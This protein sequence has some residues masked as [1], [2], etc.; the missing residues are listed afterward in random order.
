MSLG[1]SWR[2]G[3]DE[4]E[5]TALVTNGAYRL[6]RNPVFTSAATAFLGLAI[7]V[8][9]AVAVAGLTLTGIQIRVRLV[10]ERTCA[11]FTAPPTPVM[12]PGPAASCP[13]WA[14]CGKSPAP[15]AKA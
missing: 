12:P 9:N 14:A 8:P 13:P 1:A 10:E 3:V 5:S 6:V 4:A 11:A 15:A 7:M 2:I